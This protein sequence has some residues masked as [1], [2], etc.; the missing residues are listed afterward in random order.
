MPEK[1]F[2]SPRYRIPF[3]EFPERFA[4]HP[5]FS[6]CSVLLSRRLH[7]DIN[8]ALGETI[9]AVHLSD[10]FRTLGSANSASWDQRLTAML[11]KRFFE[12]IGISPNFISER[13][14]TGLFGCCRMIGTRWAGAII[15]EE[16]VPIIGVFQHLK[17]E[18]RNL[19]VFSRRTMDSGFDLLDHDSLLWVSREFKGQMRSPDLRT[20]STSRCLSGTTARHAVGGG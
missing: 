16:Q 1:D 8:D 6:S 7:S 9:I 3:D 14:R 10:V 2:R 13:C 19:L 12:R 20:P 11:A 5:L 15:G 17:V 4:S 18:H